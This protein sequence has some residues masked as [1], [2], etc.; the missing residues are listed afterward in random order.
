M[1]KGLYAAVS[2]MIAGVNR[3]TLKTHNIANLNTPGFKQVLTT[4]QEFQQT[5]VYPPGSNMLNTSGISFF[6][7]DVDIQLIWFFRRCRSFEIDLIKK[8]KP[9]IGRAHV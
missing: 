8:S 2:A 9:Q 3:Q 6:D 7:H 5:K 4:L 1:I